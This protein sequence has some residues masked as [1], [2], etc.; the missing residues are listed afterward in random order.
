MTKSIPWHLSSYL[1]LSMHFTPSWRSRFLSGITSI[2][3]ISLQPKILFNI[4]YS[5]SMLDMNSLSFIL[6][7]SVFLSSHLKDNF[8]GHRILDGEGFFLLALSKY[9]FIGLFKLCLDSIDSPICHFSLSV[10]FFIFNLFEVHWY[11][12]VYKLMFFNKFGKV[13]VLTS[14]NIFYSV[15]CLLSWAYIYMYVG[16]FGIVPH[17]LMFDH[18][19]SFSFSSVDYIISIDTSSSPLTSNWNF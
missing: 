14:S 1:P 7:G 19:L 18:I 17:T 15:L 16:S 11:S 3:I 6:F 12:W 4:P 13:V 10:I 8:T 2:Q 9:H 5:G